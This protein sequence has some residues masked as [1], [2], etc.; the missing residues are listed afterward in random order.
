MGGP[1][2]RCVLGALLVNLGR[3]VTVDRLITYLWSDDPP[4][5]ARSVIQVQVSHLRRS[6]PGSISTTAGGYIFDADPDSVDLYRFRRL[7]DEAARAAPEEAL[8]LLDRALSCWRGV[9][10]SGVGS[11]ALEHTVVGPLREERWSAVIAW[12]TCALGLGRHSEVVSRL[13]PLARE[14][15]FRERLQHL[16][17]TAL[18]HDNEKARA[19]AAYEDFRVRLADE[20]GVDPGPELAALHARILREDADQGRRTATE[21]TESETVYR[22]RND[23]PR[24]L[25]D[26]TGRVDV[27]RSLEKISLADE[28]GAEVCVLTAAGGG[29][30]TTTAVHFGYESAKRYPDG[31]LFIDLYGYT[32]GKEP[33]DPSSALGSLL[34]AVGVPPET[35]PESLEERS[36]LWRA[37]LMGRRTLLILD[38]ASSYSQVSPLLPS[39]PGSLTLITSRNELSGLS[40]ARFLSLGMFDE[41]S[42]LDLFSR[43]LGEERVRAEEDRAREIVRICGGLPLALR[44]IAGRMLSR[45]RWTFGHV[46]RRLGEQNRKF[47]E[48]Q[49][50]GQSVETAIDLSY[51]SLN[52]EQRSAFLTLGLM[53]GD[54]IDLAGGAALLGVSVEEGDDILQE[55]VGVCLLDEPQ[56]DVYRMHDLIRDFAL[57][58]ATAE[59]GAERVDRIRGRLAEH[60]LLTAQHAADLLGP[61]AL[62]DD[63]RSDS[64]YRTELLRREDAEEWFD[65]HRENLAD[66]IDYFAS[67]DNGEHAWRMAES[68]WRFYALH[69]Q[70]GLLVSSQERA[71]QVSDRQG[72]RR[73]RAV[74]L[75]GLGIGYYFAG[76]FDDA[77][78]M[79]TEARDLLAAVGDSR[80]SIRALANLGMVYERVGRLR[81]SAEAISGVLDHAVAL[82]DRRLESLQWSNLAV[83]RQ[84][85]GQYEEALHC[86]ARSMETVP[87]E[88]VGASAALVKRVMGEAKVG[89]GDIE[90]AL[91]DLDEALE[92]SQRLRLVGSRIYVH[93]SLGIAYRAAGC[94]EEAVEAHRAALA[95]AEESGD[96][97]GDAEILTD[98]GI[99]HA[100]AGHHEE[101][102]VALEK[103]HAIALERDERYT[104]ARACLA[105]GTLPA[106]TVT[107]DRAEGLLRT[108]A[109]ILTEVGSPDAE[110]ARAAL[111]DRFGG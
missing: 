103:A 99:T 110:R 74:T 4:R 47:R 30:K 75:I 66:T 104:V 98:L 6:I 17:I 78:R 82:G 52:D 44:V 54:S 85:L 69:G 65:L 111:A 53:I 60:Y 109:E 27:L 70:M 43:V 15:P 33:L 77:L 7:R 95:L 71:L 42:A 68:V 101:A 73:G 39:S 31:Q 34:R 8:E 2:Q 35:I 26:F 16:L 62:H 13:T 90:G 61:R 86:A 57:D 45:P 108:A 11:E 58:R 91:R 64:G 51:Q 96:R 87:E 23:L 100:E 67:R 18:W 88:D 102:A 19:L 36:A 79:L 81:D 24:D 48:L 63:E 10:F 56:G 3:E 12:A 14:E 21:P 59:F 105:L 107:A 9:P 41:R 37:T 92:L 84:A 46:A 32:A 5:T 29:G 97:S 1:R 93:N 76:R 55:L 20:L 94:P 28:E 22:V 50:D 40:G 72:N 49:V 89:L 80:G 25:P 38:N 83:V 106:P